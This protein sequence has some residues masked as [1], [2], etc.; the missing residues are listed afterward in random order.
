MIKIE[1]LFKDV[2]DKRIKFLESYHKFWLENA[3]LSWQWWILLVTSILSWV[4][5]IKFVDKKRTHLILN[6]GLFISGLSVTLDVIGTNHAAWAYPIHLYW[7]F[8]PPLIPFD[9]CYI[10]VIFMLVYQRYGQHWIN[11]V[12]AL[13]FTSAFISFIIEPL[14]HWIG[15]YALYRW[16]YIYTFPIYILM[17]C[18]VKVLMELISKKLH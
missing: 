9:L 11:F 18:L 17:A 1:F 15:I 3:F 5:W 13:I 2:Q 8:I 6:Y 14:F 16:K 4:I 7:A 10:P 12:I